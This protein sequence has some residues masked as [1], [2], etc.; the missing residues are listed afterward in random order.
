MEQELVK[1]FNKFSAKNGVQFDWSN[2][3]VR[4]LNESI[5]WG[6]SSDFKV[7]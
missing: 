4:N 5:F 7:I 2:S 3:V 1:V 6:T